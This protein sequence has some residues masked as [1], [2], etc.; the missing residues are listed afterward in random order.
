MGVTLQ[1][2]RYFVALEEQRNFTRAASREFVSQQ[3]FSKAISELETSVGTPLFHRTP[4]GVVPSVVG[5][6]L[7][8]PVRRTLD[9]IDSGLTDAKALADGQAT[10][11]RVGMVPGG[12]AGELMACV[13]RTFRAKHPDINIEL[14]EPRWEDPTGGVRSEVC[15]VGF[16]RRP[17]DA[18]GL[19]VR[20]LFDEPLDLCVSTKHRL[21]DRAEV[22]LEEAVAEPLLLA[23]GATPEWDRFWLLCEQRGCMPLLTAT[24]G[25]L[26]E[27][28][29]TVSTGQA[30]TLLAASTIRTVCAPGV[31]CLPIIDGP[32]STVCIVWNALRLTPSVQAFID[33]VDQVV[34]T[35]TE[36][37]AALTAGCAPG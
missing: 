23:R 3:A 19:G 8:G 1:K 37:L 29:A 17:I 30:A 10:A 35:E 6:F 9:L 7:I 22:T 26:A 25:T 13:F 16:A 24:A 12:G 15:D 5:N 31:R 36:L 33:V 20:D 34:S 21:A 32:A 2:L 14:H 4:Q 28:I 27:E 11:L 18:E